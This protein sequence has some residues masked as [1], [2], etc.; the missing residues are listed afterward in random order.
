MVASTKLRESVLGRF[1]NCTGLQS[2]VLALDSGCR[3]C[4]VPGADGQGLDPESK[5]M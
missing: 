3:L 5:A 1:W 2:D 4:P